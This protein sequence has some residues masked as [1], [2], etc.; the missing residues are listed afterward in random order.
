MMR[1]HLVVKRGSSTLHDDYYDAEITPD[2]ILKF[3]DG[4][5]FCR[6]VQMTEADFILVRDVGWFA[7]FNFE[8]GPDQYEYHFR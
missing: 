5:P 7:K 8:F 6:D 1:V 2:N 3:K 4:S